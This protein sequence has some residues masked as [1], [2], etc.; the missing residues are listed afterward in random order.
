[1]ALSTVVALP[2]VVFVVFLMM[3]LERNQRDLL[4]A[5]TAED[6]QLVARAV[7][8]SLQDMTTTLRILSTSPELEGGDFEAFHERPHNRLRSSLLYLLIAEKEENGRASG[9]E[10]GWTNG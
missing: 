8:R 2:L 10:R 5:D 6:A 4:A 9:K 1:M 7:D 3:E